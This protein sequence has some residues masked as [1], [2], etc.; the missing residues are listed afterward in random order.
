[1]FT[2]KIE[3]TQVMQ[4]TDENN[5]GLPYN[6]LK[7]TTLLYLVIEGVVYAFLKGTPLIVWKHGDYRILYQFVANKVFL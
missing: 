7:F 4:Y 2:N 6:S 5:W 1:M 3:Q